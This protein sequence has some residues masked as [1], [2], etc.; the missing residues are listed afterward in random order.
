MSQDD[1]DRPMTSEEVVKAFRDKIKPLSPEGRALLGGWRVVLR[2]KPRDRSKGD[3]EQG[4]ADAAG[5]TAPASG[6][7]KAQALRHRVTPLPPELR[8]KLRQWHVVSVR[9]PPADTG[10]SE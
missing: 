7:S 2:P 10:R 5:P 4:E 8:E 9:K 1:Q 6:E 3:T